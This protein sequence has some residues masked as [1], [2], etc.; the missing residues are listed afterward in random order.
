MIKPVAA[1]IALGASLVGAGALALYFLLKEVC[2]S[3][4]PFLI[5]LMSYS[6]LLKFRTMR[7]IKQ[8]NSY[9]A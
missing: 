5:I 6:L 3:L 4:D 7:S 1:T 2:I 8:L 9:Q